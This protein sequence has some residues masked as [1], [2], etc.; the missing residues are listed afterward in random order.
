MSAKRELQPRIY[1]KEHRWTQ[2]LW[3]SFLILFIRVNP[4]LNVVRA[5]RSLQAGRLRSQRSQAVATRA[6]GS[7]SNRVHQWTFLDPFYPR[8]SAAE[9]RASRSLQAGRLRSQHLRFL[10]LR[11]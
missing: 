10:R 1:A 7:V 4:R 3:L 2:T 11:S 5:S 8:E 9:V 6:F